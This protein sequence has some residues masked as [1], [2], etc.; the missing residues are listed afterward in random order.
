MSI[1]SIVKGFIGYRGTGRHLIDACK[2]P[3]ELSNEDLD[4]IA[5]WL[6]Q[7]PDGVTPQLLREIAD[8]FGEEQKGERHG[9]G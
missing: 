7:A 3:K 9:L 4:N 1:E 8:R 2:A 5:T 6:R